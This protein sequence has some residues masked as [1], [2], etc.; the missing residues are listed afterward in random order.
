MSEGVIEIGV[1]WIED[2]SMAESEIKVYNE[3][4]GA[5]VDSY[6]TRIPPLILLPGVSMNSGLDIRIVDPTG[7]TR[8]QWIESYKTAI[9]ACA[10]WQKI[11]IGDQM[12]V[13]SLVLVG[14]T[15]PNLVSGIG[16]PA[17]E[18]FTPVDATDEIHKILVT[19]L[20]KNKIFTVVI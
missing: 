15:I 5:D 17:V 9:N 10:V 19:D 11:Q 7:D 4:P 1:K 20:P 3:S 8:P 14:N 18:G 16:G 6:K 12:P 13:Q 2:V